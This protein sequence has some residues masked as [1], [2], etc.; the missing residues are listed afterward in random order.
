M[1]STFSKDNLTVDIKD[2]TSFTNNKGEKDSFLSAV[3][4]YDGV[5]RNDKIDGEI[6]KYVLKNADY[7]GIQA[8]EGN[9]QMNI[10]SRYYARAYYDIIV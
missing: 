9:V 5:S 7:L 10:P 6:L 8:A 2:W 4:T 1:L 3:V